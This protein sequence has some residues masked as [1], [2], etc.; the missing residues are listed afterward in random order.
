M[1]HLAEVHTLYETN[2]AD[3]PAML[4]MAADNIESGRT[5][6]QAI[7]AVVVDIDGDISVLGWGETN[8][9]DTLATLQLGIANM[10]RRLLGE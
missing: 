4:R 10:T 6:T 3:I 8:S 7:V 1:T 2:A 5:P 9:M